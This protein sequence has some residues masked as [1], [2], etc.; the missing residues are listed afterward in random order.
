MGW[1][2]DGTLLA[3]TD[4]DGV[5][6]NGV[7]AGWSMDEAWI[8][9]FLE[10]QFAVGFDVLDVQGDISIEFYGD[11]SLNIQYIKP[12]RKLRF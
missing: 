6:P 8:W 12:N 3:A 10:P 4:V 7:Q 2:V 5:S 11:I 9:D 1:E